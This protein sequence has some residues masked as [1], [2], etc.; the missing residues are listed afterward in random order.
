MLS[1]L[2]QKPIDGAQPIVY[3]SISPNLEGKGGT[4]ISNCRIYP[5]AE[6]AKSD[7]LQEKLFNFT[8]NLLNI[9]KFGASQEN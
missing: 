8:N 9:K 1:F 7:E 2:L 6:I 3:T 4:Y 5:I